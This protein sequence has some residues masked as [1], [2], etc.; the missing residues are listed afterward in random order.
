MELPTPSEIIQ[1]IDAFLTRHDMAATRFGRDATKN[2]NIVGLL[3]GGHEPSIGVL[4]RLK[5][6]MDRKDAELA[7]GDHAVG[8]TA[9]APAPSSGRMDEVSQEVRA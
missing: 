2:Q 9:A 5:D 7:G 4:R 8:D 6:F 3:R 1:S